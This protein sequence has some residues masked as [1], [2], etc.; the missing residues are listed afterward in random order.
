MVIEIA[1]YSLFMSD[2]WHRSIQCNHIAN[3]RRVSIFLEQLLIQLDVFAFFQLDRPPVLSRAFSV[4]L[5]C[6]KCIVMPV[7]S[8]T[9]DVPGATV[10]E[11]LVADVTIVEGILEVGNTFVPVYDEYHRDNHTREHKQKLQN[12]LADRG[13]ANLQ[14]MK[15][16]GGGENS[17]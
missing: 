8:Q 15:V 5:V 4:F 17:H 11:R 10:E 12:P 3:H 13:F 14:W 2:V 7:D 9:V 6:H 16:R 1:R